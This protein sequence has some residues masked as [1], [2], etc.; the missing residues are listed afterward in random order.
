MTAM[1][2]CCGGTFPES[3][4]KYGCPLCCG[5]KVARYRTAPANPQPEHTEAQYAEQA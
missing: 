4:G 5:E 3:L 2:E 1:Y